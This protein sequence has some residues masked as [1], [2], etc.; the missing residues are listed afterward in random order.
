MKKGEIFWGKKEKILGKGRKNLGKEKILGK[1]KFGKGRKIF[2]ND[3][4]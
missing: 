2:G 4:K 1:E 3:E